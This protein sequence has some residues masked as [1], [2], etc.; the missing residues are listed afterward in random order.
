M[1]E[2][3]VQAVGNSA[4]IKVGHYTIGGVYEKALSTIETYH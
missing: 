2:L 4:L 3:L 1:A